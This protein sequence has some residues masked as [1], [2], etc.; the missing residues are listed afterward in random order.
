[1]LHLHLVFGVSCP[2]A[3]VAVDEYVQYLS[4]N[5]PRAYFGFVDRKAEGGE[6]CQVGSLTGAVAS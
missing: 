6:Q 2:R 3:A 1:V 5:A 4:D